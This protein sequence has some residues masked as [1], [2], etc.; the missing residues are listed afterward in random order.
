[1]QISVDNKKPA[2]LTSLEVTPL[3]K[4][5]PLRQRDVLLFREVTGAREA[6]LT[7]G[8]CKWR[9]RA[10]LGEPDELALV[11]PFRGDEVYLMVHDP[12]AR[13]AKHGSVDSSRVFNRGENRNE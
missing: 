5:I 2:N 7:K 8:V 12:I 10:R 13:T 6:E 11:A 3:H 9:T 1:M 4:C